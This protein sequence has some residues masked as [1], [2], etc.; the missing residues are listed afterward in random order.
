MTVSCW[1]SSTVW[2]Y[3][4]CKH[5]CDR[6]RSHPTKLSMQ[7]L[8]QTVPQLIIVNKMGINNG[9]LHS[10]KSVMPG[11]QYWSL[12]VSGNF[13]SFGIVTHGA[14]CHA[15]FLCWG[16]PYLSPTVY[17]IRWDS[18]GDLISSVIHTGFIHTVMHRSLQT[19]AVLK[20]HWFERY[21]WCDIIACIHESIQSKLPV[22]SWVINNIITHQNKVYK[23][24]WTYIGGDVM[25][26]ILR[27][28][29]C[30]KLLESRSLPW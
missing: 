15:G 19:I 8:I 21:K 26:C 22:F 9:S 30:Y 12:P 4:I 23:S 24:S 27:M 3:D 16:L 5:N 13:Q 14:C 20:I 11:A 17:L 6:L 25:M 10:G 28:A 1:V 18:T 29:Y 2:W 7:L